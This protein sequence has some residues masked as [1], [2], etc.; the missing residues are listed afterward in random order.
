MKPRTGLKSGILA[1][2]SLG[3]SSTAPLMVANVIVNGGF[4]EP[5][6]GAQGNNFPASV[7]NWEVVLN[8][9]SAPCGSGHNI[10]LA[11]A[12][13]GGGPDVAVD[14]TQYYDICGAA[15]YVMQGF[16]IGSESMI[17]FGAS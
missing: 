2:I 3:V 9:G 14:G 5:V 10:I 17:T 16:T 7:P 15:G 12:G 1:G 13:Y 6:A 4:E 11:H 8:P